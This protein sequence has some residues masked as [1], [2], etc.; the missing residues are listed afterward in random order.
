MLP[1]AI[2]AIIALSLFSGCTDYRW[3]DTTEE[4]VQGVWTYERVRF[5]RSAFQSSN[6]RTAEFQG[7]SLEFRG[8]FT[9]VQRDEING[10]EISGNWWLDQEVSWYDPEDDVTHFTEILSGSFLDPFTNERAFF[11]WEDLAVTNQKMTFREFR[12]GGTWNYTLRRRW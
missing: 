10:T 8:D 2:P 9:F 12:D 6:D 5:K 7:L 4:K 11:A 1:L 3:F